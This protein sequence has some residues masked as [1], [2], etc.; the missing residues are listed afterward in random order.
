MRAR[1]LFLFL[2]LT[3]L[4]ILLLLTAAF[5]LFVTIAEYRPKAVEKADIN[6]NAKKMILQ[7]DEVLKVL[8]WN[9]GY[10]GLDA[11]NDFFYDG[12][13]NVTAR[14]KEAVLDNLEKVKALLKK[15]DCGFN[16]LQ[17]IDVK[18]RRSFYVNQKKTLSDFFADYD[19]VFAANYDAVIVP[20]PVLNPLGRVKSGVFTL[21]KYGIQKAERLQLSGTFSWPLKTVNLKRCLLVSEIKTD[22]PNKNLYIINLHLS[23]YDADGVLR[24]QEMEF[25]Q[26]LA[27]KLYNEGH[28]V[29]AGGDWNSLFPGV[30][31]NRFIPYTTSDEFLEWIEYLPADFIGKEWKWG[32]D[33]STP[34]VR[35]LEKPYVKGENYTTIIDGF[36]C[37]PNVEIIGVKTAGLNF[38][39]SDHHPVI[40][41]FTLMK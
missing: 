20:A 32:F 7:T 15:E 19:S 11:Q 12:G 21:S 17:E 40:A 38:E 37:S 28:W 36:I 13:K 25:L 14:S 31:K 18:S 9:I 41:E 26:N 27:L 22:V 34:T 5:F 35:L 33:S 23:A 29:I 6:V 4:A 2:P 16:L 39:V 3:V 1:R 8:N 10:C 30:E 24:K